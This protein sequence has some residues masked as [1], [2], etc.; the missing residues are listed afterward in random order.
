[1]E[2]ACDSDFRTVNGHV[3][4][5]AVVHWHI[6]PIAGVHNALRIHQYGRYV[7]Q[8]WETA[9]NTRARKPNVMAG[10][11]FKLA[12]SNLSQRSFPPIL[13]PET[14]SGVNIGGQLLWDKLG[15]GEFER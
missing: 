2:Q 3:G 8:Y 9:L 7:Q 13:M 11:H 1:M 6:L 10:R 14:L 5:I 15:D 12:V 4:S